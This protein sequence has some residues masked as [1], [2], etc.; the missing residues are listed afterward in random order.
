MDQNKRLEKLQLALTHEHWEIQSPGSFSDGLVMSES[1][2]LLV[3]AA[4]TL[5]GSSQSSTASLATPGAAVRASRAGPREKPLRNK[6]LWHWQGWGRHTAVQSP[7]HTS[8]ERGGLAG[9]R[10]SIVPVSVQS[11]SVPQ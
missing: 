5:G 11:V 9:G 8:L 3:A 7:A 10:Y 4:L 2:H 6:F 1:R